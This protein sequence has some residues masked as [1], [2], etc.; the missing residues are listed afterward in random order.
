MLIHSC[1][2]VC[3]CSSKKDTQKQICL[4][5]RAT[6]TTCPPWPGFPVVRQFN[7]FESAYVQESTVVGGH[8][9]LGRCRPS[10]SGVSCGLWV[11]FVGVQSPR[12]AWAALR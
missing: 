3:V 10:M 5:F 12:E 2:C 6:H 8:S 1:V 11:A 7:G 9:G 4:C